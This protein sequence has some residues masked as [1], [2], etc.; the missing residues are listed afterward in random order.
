MLLDASPFAVDAF[1]YCSD[2]FPCFVW[3]R[4]F[5]LFGSC[6]RHTT[7]DV[8]PTMGDTFDQLTHATTPLISKLTTL[9]CS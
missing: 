4:F 3:M 2:A 1:P 7:L 5:G 6:L 9:V 8:S